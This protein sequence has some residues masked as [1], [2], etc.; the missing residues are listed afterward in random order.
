MNIRSTSSTKSSGFPFKGKISYK[1]T[2]VLIGAVAALLVISNLV[3]E[4]AQTKEGVGVAA[5]PGGWLS[6]FGARNASLKDQAVAGDTGLRPADC[7]LG[8]QSP[9]TQGATI[10]N[11][12][13]G[14]LQSQTLVVQP[15]ADQEAALIVE[16]L[17]DLAAKMDKFQS[18]AEPALL[19]NVVM[20]ADECQRGSL[21]TVG[22]S[23]ACAAVVARRD[24]ALAALEQAAVKTGN[25]SAQYLY[26]TLLQINATSGV[27]ISSDPA[28]RAA[29]YQRGEDMIRRAAAAGD[30]GAKGMVE[31]MES[32]KSGAAAESK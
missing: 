3:F 13:L 22:K 2:G 11:G 5:G 31:F 15:S 6:V 21:P 18:S 17:V 23:A 12:G 7:G 14:A 28:V 16:N 1:K 25:S 30:V 8:T 4:A 29:E 24:S 26:G 27:R 20:A 19:A 32:V 10:C 9:F